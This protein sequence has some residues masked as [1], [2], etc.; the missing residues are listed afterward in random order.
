M[1]VWL[2][3][4]YSSIQA[5]HVYRPIPNVVWQDVREHRGTL[6]SHNE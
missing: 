5:F 1:Q 6:H 4:P 2:A 3:T